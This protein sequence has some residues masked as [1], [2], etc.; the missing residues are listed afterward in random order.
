MRTGFAV[1]GLVVGWSLAVLLVVM[2]ASVARADACTLEGGAPSSDVFYRHLGDDCTHQQREAR[3]I[4]A[5]DVLAALHNGRGVVLEGVVVTGDLMLDQL[6]G[7]PL[8]TIDTLPHAIGDSLRERGVQ[9][10]RV[11][12]GPI[13]VHKSR[14]EGVWATNLVKEGY[15]LI[16]QPFALTESTFERSIDFSRA[17]FLDPV[18]FSDTTILHEAFFIQARFHQEARFARTAF[19]TH[20][21]FFRAIFEGPASFQRAGFN[22]LAEF[23]EVTFEQNAIFSRTHFKMGTGFSGSRFRGKLDFSEAVFE[24]EG[25]FMYTTFQDDAYFRRTV[26]EKQADFTKAEFHGVS[27]FSKVRFEVPP[28]VDETLLAPSTKPLRGL[29][30]PRIQYGIVAAMAIFALAFVLFLKYR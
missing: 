16:Q 4:A 28:R 14:I 1:Y 21:R 5:E 10:L 7:V 11:I 13:R 6:P 17:I 22:G 2:L 24:R 26:F 15:I 19:G 30:D 3:A 8:G 29:Q 27:D 23:L 20:S 9:T 25:Y 18:D 12:K